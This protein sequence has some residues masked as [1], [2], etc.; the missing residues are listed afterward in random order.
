MGIDGKDE[1]GLK[2]AR[3][4]RYEVVRLMFVRMGHQFSQV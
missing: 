4:I 3:L 1:V 2:N